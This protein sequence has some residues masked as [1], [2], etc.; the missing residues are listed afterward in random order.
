M[1]IAYATPVGIGRPGGGATRDQA[2]NKKQIILVGAV[3]L[4]LLAEL[5]AA[6]YAAAQAPDAFTATFIKTFFA[7]LAPT[8]ALGIVGVRM[9]RGKPQSPAKPA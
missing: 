9:L 8:L 7:L 3:D 5:F 6:M 4:A 2:M 1:R